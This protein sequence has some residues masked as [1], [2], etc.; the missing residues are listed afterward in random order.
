M[1]R[2]V[3]LLSGSFESSDV[4]EVSDS[5]IEKEVMLVYP[6]TFQSMD[7][8]VEITDEHLQKL[9]GN[10]NSFVG[11]LAKMAGGEM[12]LKNCPPIQLD[13][14]VSA[15]DTVG[16]LVG[17]L[18]IKPHSL[19]DGTQTKALFGKMRVL[20]K[21]NIEKV[22]D[23]RWTH[24]SIG[25]DLDEGKLTEL[26]ITPFPAAPEA[27]MLSRLGP[28][29]KM[30]FKGFDV[31]YGFSEQ[32]SS[33]V[34]FVGNQVFKGADEQSALEKAKEWADQAAKKI[35][36]GKFSQGEVM[37]E[38]LLKYLAKFKKLSAE[39]AEKKMG[40]MKDDEKEKLAAEYEKH[41]K[42]KKHL[43]EKEKLA[44]EAVEKKLAEMDD[45]SKK[46]LESEIAHKEKLAAEEEEKKKL[47]A[48][49]EEKKKL[50][51]QD[52][53]KK[54]SAA[55]EKLTQLRSDFRSASESARLAQRKISVTTRLSSLKAA[56]KVTPAEI[57]KMD[58]AKLAAQTDEEL[59]A[60]F[61][62]FEVREPQVMIGMM[63]NAN[64]ED[65]ARLTKKKK[66]A[67]ME[68]TVLAS[69][70]FLSGVKRLQEG[71]QEGAQDSVSIH[72]DTDPHTD[73]AGEESEIEKLMDSD[74]AKA[75]DA[76]RAYCKKLKGR[77]TGA[78]DGELAGEEKSVQ[79]LA[80]G[81]KKMQ[82]QMEQLLKL[83]A[84]VTGETK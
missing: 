71:E 69:M 45:D 37:K 57:K 2:P 9:M 31:E 39:E 11:K 78:P 8:E 82:N 16:R 14:S 1:P 18:E 58:I 76:F 42:L 60:F 29:K 33:Y 80:D 50:A 81:V 21:E 20:G 70:P 38:K 73:L 5:A 10:H 3:K 72:V 35:V 17:A 64:A 41:E 48:E 66:M 36:E 49:E 83:C 52:P 47:A 15:R 19:S 7:G 44:E 65:I 26:S 22:K 74:I 28:M 77:M 51:E 59:D 13:H 84:D 25:A 32:L 53:E 56:A 46:K 43:I 12:P 40:E 23:G 6:G 4:T 62:G 34:A 54:L 67:D 75:K 61:K 63:G 55:R 27:A 68:K 30:K 79:E 24:V